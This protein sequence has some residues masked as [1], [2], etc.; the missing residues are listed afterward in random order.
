MNLTNVDKG[1]Y[2]ITEIRSNCKMRNKFCLLG[3]RVGEIIEKITND[4]I[5]RW[6]DATYCLG[7]KIG[8]KIKVTKCE[9]E[10]KNEMPTM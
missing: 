2:I 6:K 4:N 1:N 7:H 3:L 10:D 5:I 8:L 9:K